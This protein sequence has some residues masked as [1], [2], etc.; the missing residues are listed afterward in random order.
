MTVLRRMSKGGLQQSLVGDVGG[1]PSAVPTVKAPHEGFRPVLPV[2]LG[3]FEV[4]PLSKRHV[5]VDRPHL[6]TRRLTHVPSPSG[7]KPRV[8]MNSLSLRRASWIRHAIVP[9][10]AP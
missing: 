3:F 5:E 2:S 1:R 8:S 6:A 9:S 7:S 4:W 10:G